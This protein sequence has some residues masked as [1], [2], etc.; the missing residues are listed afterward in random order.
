MRITLTELESVGA[1]D[2]GTAWF[3][4]RYGESAD[5]ATVWDDLGETDAPADAADWRVRLLSHHIDWTATLL[6]DRDVDIDAYDTHVT[7]FSARCTKADKMMARALKGLATEAVDAITD[8]V[9]YDADW[10]DTARAV[11]EACRDRDSGAL[12][13]EALD[14]F[15]HW[16][17]GPDDP[18]IAARTK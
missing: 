15:L 13:L 14:E 11:V 9:D 12:D 6:L 7:L 3:S 1:C 2:D 16:F 4:A 8:L 5:L 17:D 18:R 10:H